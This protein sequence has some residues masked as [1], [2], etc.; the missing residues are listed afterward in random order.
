MVKSLLTLQHCC[1]KLWYDMMIK[2][3]RYSVV[4]SKL[5][6]RVVSSQILSRYFAFLPQSK[7]MHLVSLSDSRLAIAV[8]LT[9]CGCQPLSVSTVTVSL[10]LCRLPCVSFG[11]TCVKVSWTSS[12]HSEFM[13]FCM[14]VNFFVAVWPTETLHHSAAAMHA[15]LRL[16]SLKVQQEFLLITAACSCQ[17]L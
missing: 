6:T 9:V 1:F 11:S 12:F 14:T 7:M 13:H 3:G 15:P 2:S 4:T 17:Y 5:A 8:D 16:T 10:L